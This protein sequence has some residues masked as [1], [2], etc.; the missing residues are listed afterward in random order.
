MKQSKA[1]KLTAHLVS[2]TA[3]ASLVNEAPG[4]AVAVSFPQVRGVQN[5]AVFRDGDEELSKLGYAGLV[6]L[7]FTYAP[8]PL[9]VIRQQADQA[10]RFLKRTRDNSVRESAQ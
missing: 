3:R 4:K 9:R 10:T 7:G 2:A 5:V 1:V 8:D 6:E